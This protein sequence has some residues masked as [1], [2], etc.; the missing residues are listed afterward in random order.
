M[1]KKL[2]DWQVQGQAPKKDTTDRI[3]V[4]LIPNYM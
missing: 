3:S 1:Y 2:R 4:E